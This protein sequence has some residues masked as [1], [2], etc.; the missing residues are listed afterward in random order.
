MAVNSGVKQITFPVKDAAKSKELYRRLLG[1]EP[2]ADF[3]GYVGFRLD[4]QEIGLVPPGMQGVV[5]PTDYFQVADIRQTVKALTEAGA[6]IRKDVWDV[7][8][9]RLVALVEDPDGN[10]IG[11]IQDPVHKEN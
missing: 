5:E 11:L 3:P 1:V 9:G 10:I 4:G 2:Y 8:M 6:K 7:G